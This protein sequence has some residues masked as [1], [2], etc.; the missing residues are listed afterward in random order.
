MINTKQK[1]N[2][3]IHYGVPGM[4]WGVRKKYY[5]EKHG[6]GAKKAAYKA[7][8]KQYNAAFNKAY[9][10]TNNHSLTALTGGITKRGKARAKKMESDWGKVVDASQARYD[11]KKTYKSAKKAAKQ[12]LRNEKK[13]TIKRKKEHPYLTAKK[14]LY[15]HTRKQQAVNIVRNYANLNTNN[16]VLRQATNTGA[17][18][19]SNRLLK[20]YLDK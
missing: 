19:V 3:L 18:W 14:E 11:A 1:K 5:Y 12:E 16:P 17:N 6:V 15:S 7:A 4:K 2:E 9:A 10:Y 8:N 20:D 13:S